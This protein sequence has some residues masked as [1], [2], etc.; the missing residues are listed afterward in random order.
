MQSFLALVNK[1]IEKV[2]EK[3]NENFPEIITAEEVISMWCEQQQIS[4]HEAT[5]EKL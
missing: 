4:D 3:V 1:E 2:A 5:V